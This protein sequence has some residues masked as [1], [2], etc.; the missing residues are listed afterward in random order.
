MLLRVLLEHWYYFGIS[1]PARGLPFI[2]VVHAFDSFQGIQEGWNRYNAQS[3][4]MDGKPPELVAGLSNVK[5]HVGYFTQTLQALSGFRSQPVA[6]AHIDSDL[7]SSAREVLSYLRCQLV[8][9]TVLVFDEWFNYAGWQ[10]GGEYRAWRLFAEN[11][12][13][14]W[15]PLGFHFEQAV[16][17][18]VESL[19]EGCYI[20]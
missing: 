3:F 17:I 16:P 2:I 15:R 13:V 11:Y 8:P 4:G 14:R 19:P 20:E 10:K 9:G 7:F 6:F 12:G 18:V 5:L 1:P